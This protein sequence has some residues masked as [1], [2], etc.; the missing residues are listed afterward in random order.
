MRRR[1]ENGF[2]LLELTLSMAMLTV[3]AGA[4]FMLL[5]SA[6]NSTFNNAELTSM[7]SAVRSAAELIGQEIGQAGLPPAPTTLTS[8]IGVNGTT[9]NVASVNGLF[10]GEIVTVDP[11]P[12]Q[13][14]VQV[15]TVGGGSF[16]I[17]TALPTTT[18]P[19]CTA[20]GQFQ[21]AHLSGAAVIV[22]GA[23][24]QA[25]G[26]YYPSGVQSTMVP[27]GTVLR[28]FG[29]IR[30]DGSL[31]Y[32]EYNCNFN[33]QAASAVGLGTHT[34]GQLTRS[35][36]VITP[37]TTASTPKNPPEVLVDNLIFLPE[38]GVTTP[39][40]FK[41]QYTPMC[42]TSPCTDTPPAASVSIYGQTQ[43]IVTGV[44]LKISVQ[45]VRPN[46]KTGQY[47]SL[48]KSFLNLSPRNVLYAEEMGALPSPPPGM[49]QPT[50]AVLPLIH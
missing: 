48:S 45:S 10:P 27:T 38:A 25:V 44:G 18:P 35:V 8:A 31:V 17:C 20:G 4:G 16:T 22:Q 29:D 9:A 43:N 24:Y 41:Y 28:L 19:S 36:T 50:P 5:N 6:Q 46:P 32:V 1:A 12:N 42:N 23:F 11:G 47:W 34:P 39:Y 30:G 37:S 3:V 21:I 15:S 26:T 7:Y 33:G 2:T 40:C 13:E 14:I 49:V